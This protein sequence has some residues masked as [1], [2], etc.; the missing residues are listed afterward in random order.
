M[1]D[2]IPLNCRAGLDEIRAI[3]TE[4]AAHEKQLTQR[5]E[6]MAEAVEL[7]HHDVQSFRPP[8]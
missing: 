4:L 1:A 6:A 5:H 7:F 3:L 2:A 8:R